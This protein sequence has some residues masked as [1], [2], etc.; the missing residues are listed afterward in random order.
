VLRV[1]RIRGIS[2]AT[3]LRQGKI[4]GKQG[5]AALDVGSTYNNACS[6]ERAGRVIVRV[7]LVEDDEAV[8]SFVRRGLVQEGYSVD[9]STEG[10]DAFH[11]ALDVSYD[12]IILDVVIPY[13]DGFEVVRGIR[14]EGRNVP[15]LMLSGKNGI[16]ERVRGLD[17]GAD[18]YL[19][20]PFSF[21]ELSARVRALSRRRGEIWQPSVEYG[22]F[23]IDFAAHKVTRQERVID[24]TA[25]EFAL[26]AYLVRNRGTVVTRTMIAEHVWDQHYDSFSNIVDVYVRYLRAKLDDGFEWKLIQT[27]R[28]VGYVFSS[29]TQ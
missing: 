20:K 18:D 1:P 17:S 4:G 15:I 3:G 2:K 16:E 19:I 7:L 11:R 5:S 6:G 8:S 14:K 13:I 23:K 26:L 21:E 12:V 28:G 25:K 29:Q 9:V 24:L 27:V 22:N 10:R